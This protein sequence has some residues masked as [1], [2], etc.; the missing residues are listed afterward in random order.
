MI[1]PSTLNIRTAPCI[2]NDVPTDGRRR[3][4]PSI[5]PADG[6]VHR[7]HP[8][9][10]PPQLHAAIRSLRA[11]IV[12]NRSD[13]YKFRYINGASPTTLRKGMVTVRWWGEGLT[14]RRPSC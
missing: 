3:A 13:V 2:V 12:P 6:A 5:R 9:D 10:R 7:Q 1:V 11:P 14:C 8:P 4:G